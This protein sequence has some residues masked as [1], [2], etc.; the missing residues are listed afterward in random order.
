[1]SLSFSVRLSVKRSTKT[2]TSRD[3]PTDGREPFPQSLPIDQHPLKKGLMKIKLVLR[4]IKDNGPGAIKDLGGNL[5]FPVCRQAGHDKHIGFPHVHQ[6]PVY[7]KSPEIG[8]PFSPLVFLSHA[9]PDIRIY[10]VGPIRS[11]PW[12]VSQ[13]DIRTRA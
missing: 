7:L 8:A 3:S 10:N 12:I 1:M 6:C 11:V 4:L 5:F 2:D 9:G 13:A